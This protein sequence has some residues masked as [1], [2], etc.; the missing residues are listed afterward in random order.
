MHVG[1]DQTELNKHIANVS[2]GTKEP[3]MTGARS[4]RAR[5]TAKTH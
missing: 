4:A 2:Y 1:T 3:K 5:S